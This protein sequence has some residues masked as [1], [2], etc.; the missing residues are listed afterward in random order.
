MFVK[1][2][3]RRLA[4][5]CC[6]IYFQDCIKLYVLEKRTKVTNTLSLFMCNV[7]QI[8]LFL[9]S[10]F[11]LCFFMDTDI[12][13]L[14]YYGIN[15]YK[16]CLLRK[17]YRY[18]IS[19]SGAHIAFESWY[20]GCV[21]LNGHIWWH[22]MCVSVVFLFLLTIKFLFQNSRDWK[23]CCINI[24]NYCYINMPTSLI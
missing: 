9:I 10:W 6:I 2:F 5:Q 20:D 4:R 11:S 21:P 19:V 18:S 24:W 7:L 17:N 8:S 16:K 23:Y 3:R 22:Y 1:F 13:K 12:R 15:V 14:Y